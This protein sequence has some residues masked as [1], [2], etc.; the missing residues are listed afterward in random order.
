ME[1]SMRLCV[2]RVYVGVSSRL[3]HRHH[4]GLPAIQDSHCQQFKT[5]NR[6]FE[7]SVLFQYQLHYDTNEV[8]PEALNGPDGLADDPGCQTDPPTP[9]VGA[10]CDGLD[11]STIIVFTSEDTLNGPVRT[12]LPRVSY[13]G[14]PIFHRVEVS[15]TASDPPID[16]MVPA[17]PTCPSS[18]SWLGLPEHVR[19]S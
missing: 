5:L 12:T 6:R 1:W 10:V 13:C 7:R 16:P 19:H 17:G 3:S 14:S 2:I 15:G 18:P 8:P 9:P 4:R 11:P